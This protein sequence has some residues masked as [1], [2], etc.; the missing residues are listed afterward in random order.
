MGNFTLIK[1]GKLFDGVT[2]R[3]LENQSILVDGETIIQ[4]GD[5]FEVPEGTT[6][7]D[8]QDKVVTPG[9]SDIHTHYTAYNNASVP[10]ILS[11]LLTKTPAYRAIGAVHHLQELLNHGF[12]LI[13]ECG[14]VEKG[15]ELADVRNAIRDKA[16]DG[17]T[18][19]VCGHSG[20]I[21]GGH[22]DLRQFVSNMAAQDDILKIPSIGSGAQFF[23]QWVRTEFVHGVDFIKF[24]ID[25]GFATP[26]D[27]PEHRHMSEEE[28]KT[29]IETAHACNLKATAHIYGDESA[30]IAL[31]YGIDGIEHSGLLSPETYDLIAEKGVYVVPTMCFF[32]R[33]VF[34]DEK[35]LA[36]VPKFMADKYRQKH[37]KLCRARE[38]LI[39]HIENDTILVGA[40]TDLGCVE[41]MTEAYKEYETMIRSG[42]SPF[43]ALRVMTSNSAKI[44]GRNDLG[45]IAVG[46]KADIV[47]WAQDPVE[48]AQAF[49]ECDFVMKHGKIIKN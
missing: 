30:R 33:G 19:V 8:L 14:S 49:R 1:C 22:M 26:H 47:A 44:V 41:P 39:R 11:E 15:W 29:I 4:V 24:H 5:N 6:V 37:E 21:D 43:K 12:T 31:K 25:G 27:D 46:K 20:G 2:E 42:V 38:A 36:H 32:D 3:Y 16:V 40:G 17:P 13:R 23:Q 9:L 10:T 28:I 34:L 45:H 48:N 18:L 35:E 7:I